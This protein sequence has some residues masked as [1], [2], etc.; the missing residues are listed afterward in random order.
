MRIERDILRIAR[1]IIS[2]MAPIGISDKGRA[3]LDNLQ[4]GREKKQIFNVDYESAKQILSRD[5]ERAT[6]PYRISEVLARFLYSASD[7]L[8]SLN[9]MAKYVRTVRLFL[10]RGNMSTFVERARAYNDERDKLIIGD[11]GRYVKEAEEHLKV[12]ETWEVVLS[13]IKEVRGY[14]TKGRRPIERAPDYIPNRY[15]PPMAGGEAIRLVTDKLV[16]IVEPQKGNVAK[17]MMDNYIA[18]V[19]AY[20]GG[21][22]YRAVRNYLK[23]NYMEDMMDVI[24]ENGYAGMVGLRGDYKE[25]IERAVEGK[26]QSMIERYVTK[27]VGKIAS[28]IHGKG[29]PSKVEVGS[30]RLRGWGFSGSIRFFF[31]DGTQFEVRNQAVWKMSYNGLS[32]NQFPT[33][34]HDVVFKDGSKKSMVPEQAMNEEWAKG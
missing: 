31:K 4:E 29:E 3:A 25:K 18:K 33:T 16:E 23:Q 11:W 28:I 14:V 26:V 30:G 12:I 9:G 32:F 34:F 5:F 8:L 15:V 20:N 7:T 27:N 1:S 19:E 22:G 6:D 2:D 13:L 10:T 24:Y 21:L 17:S